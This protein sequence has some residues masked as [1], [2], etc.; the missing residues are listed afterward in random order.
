MNH[1]GREGHEG[2]KP[3]LKAVTRFDDVHQSQVMSYLKTT[4]FPS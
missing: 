4:S 1:E 2:F 3:L